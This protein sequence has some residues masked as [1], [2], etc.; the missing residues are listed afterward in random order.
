MHAVCLEVPHTIPYTY[1]RSKILPHFGKQPIS[2][3]PTMNASRPIEMFLWPVCSMLPMRL[4]VFRPPTNH[5][6]H[7]W[8]R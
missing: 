7:L 4:S 8:H 6:P 2:V 5:H 3:N 1:K